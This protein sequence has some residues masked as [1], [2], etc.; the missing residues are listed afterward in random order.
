MDQGRLVNEEIE[1]GAELARRFD[2]FAPV[3]AVFWLKA[4]DSPY[5]YHYIASDHINDSNF[6]IAYGEILRLGRQI[7]S[8]SINPFRVKV[9]NSQEPVAKAAVDINQR[10]GGKKAIR[11]SEELFGGMSVDD[12]YIYP[13][14]PLP[15]A[16]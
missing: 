2:D 15:A 12:V 1:G 11:L 5:R 13:P 16:S 3:K 8:P 4:S 14:L 9:V 6:D 7:Q 10:F